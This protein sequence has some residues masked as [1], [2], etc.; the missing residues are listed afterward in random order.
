MKLH[1]HKLAFS[2]AFV[3]ALAFTVTA[4][5]FY[6][7]PLYT[8][9]FIATIVH[10]KSLALLYPYTKIGIVHFIAGLLQSFVYTYLFVWLTIQFYNVGLAKKETLS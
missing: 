2:A 8:L 9:Q 6:F 7:W 1:A 5:A 4:G 10:L 3:V